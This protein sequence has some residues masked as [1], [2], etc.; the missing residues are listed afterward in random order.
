M[1]VSTGFIWPKWEFIDQLSDRYLLKKY[2]AIWSQIQ[3]LR[4][5]IWFKG[6]L[7]QIWSTYQDSAETIIF[8]TTIAATTIPPSQH[9][10]LSW[11]VIYEYLCLLSSPKADYKVSISKIRKQNKHM[12]TNKR[13]NKET[14]III[15]IQFNS[16]F[17]NVLKSTAN[18]QLQSQHDYKQQQ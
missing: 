1:R 14:R 11:F 4:H 17:I 15:I 13:Q 16:I 2:T 12:H 10:K 8:F 9:K 18:G 5:N 3:S 7:L 6:S